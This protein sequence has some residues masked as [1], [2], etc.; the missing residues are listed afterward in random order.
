[1]G[2]LLWDRTKAGDVALSASTA[3]EQR[4]I[5]LLLGC[6]GR[7]RCCRSRITASGSRRERARGL[8]CA[9]QI[10]V[11]RVPVDRDRRRRVH[12]VATRLGAGP[13]LRLAA[14]LADFLLIRHRRR[15]SP[16]QQF[17]QAMNYVF[18]ANVVVFVPDGRCR[19]AAAQKSSL[20]T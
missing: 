20:I 18:E 7:R 13:L 19:A 15:H 6:C 9:P 2:L 16:G 8:P 11:H 4:L 14:V 5:R 1:M 12:R 10:H 17:S 3:G